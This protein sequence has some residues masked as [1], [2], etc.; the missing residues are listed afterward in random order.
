MSSN[1]SPIQQLRI[2][3]A[4]WESWVGSVVFCL[5]MSALVA[6]VLQPFK[7]ALRQFVDATVQT[8]LLHKLQDVAAATQPCAPAQT[9]VHVIGIDDDDYRNLFRQRSP[10]DPGLIE[11]LVE[12]LREAPPRVLA[13]DLD[14][15]PADDAEWP[16][17]RRLLASLEALAKTTRVLMVCPKGFDV[18][19]PGPLDHEWVALAGRKLEFVSAAVSRDGLYY[20]REGALETLGVAAWR[21]ASGNGE[22]IDGSR[23]GGVARDWASACMAAADPSVDIE[24]AQLVRPRLT[25]ASS[26]A[27]AMETPQTFRD[28]IVFLGGRWG[29][30]D[31]FWLRGV[32]FPVHGINLHAWVTQTERQP[33]FAPSAATTTVIDV[34]I[35][36]ASGGV[37]KLLWSAIGGA[38][39]SFALRSLLYSLFLATAILLPIF[40]VTS[41][42]KLAELGVVLGAAGMILSSAVDVFLSTHEG[43]LS[44]GHEDGGHAKGDGAQAARPGR[45]VARVLG[46]VAL[47]AAGAAIAAG[48][49]VVGCAVAGVAAGLALALLDAGR[50]ER[51]DPDEK[52]EKDKKDKKNEKPIDLLARLGWL[53]FLVAVFWHVAHE[54]FGPSAWA[55]LAGFAVSAAVVRIA[56][57]HGRTSSRPAEPHSA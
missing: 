44:G 5:L 24:T 10:L 9:C 33:P 22:R 11:G 12:R 26:F 17:R 50:H 43:V 36:L 21:A 3:S 42:A 25:A 6:F 54:E 19:N 41:A 1:P 28:G 47:V 34:L 53:A 29:S 13:I 18:G 40:W 4:F 52:D 57:R 38:K 39:D 27:Q 20:S 55:L 2:P 23:A 35:G 30:A 51:E 56:Y 7:P 31:M 49:A 14:L 8:S 45:W 32:D 15:S 16:A 46:T 37:F 48:D